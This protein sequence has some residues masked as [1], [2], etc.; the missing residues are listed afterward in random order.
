MLS[1]T[2]CATV[3][4]AL[5][6]AVFP[7]A[8]EARAR[9]KPLKDYPLLQCSACEQMAR[10]IGRRMN[11]TAQ[12]HKHDS[13]LKTDKKQDKKRVDYEGSELRAVEVLE[14]LCQDVRK[15]AYFMQTENK[16]R[17]FGSKEE[18]RNNEPAQLYTKP[19]E[20]R[21]SNVRGRIGDFCETVLDD[22]ED[23]LVR[24]IRKKRHL[25]DVFEG[26]CVYGLKLC[27]KAEMED[28][29]RQE[30]KRYAEY[31][32]RV[33]AGKPVPTRVG[34]YENDDDAKMQSPPKEVLD[35]VGEL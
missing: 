30:Q 35:E 18:A 26:M 23:L 24:V 12:R 7:P 10:E 14:L 21:L 5:V 8:A 31:E 4:V 28:M 15:N 11:I 16:V 1:S 17:V 9:V 33:Q 22:Y 29:I 19:E 20:S 13:V 2:V 3:C 6:L 34:R 32:A 25:K 27:D